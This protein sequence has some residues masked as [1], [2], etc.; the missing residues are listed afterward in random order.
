MRSYIQVAG[1]ASSRPERECSM[2]YDELALE[3]VDMA[4]GDDP[5]VPVAIAD[6]D[7]RPEASGIDSLDSRLMRVIRA[8]DR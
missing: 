7:P 8:L 2:I 1:S 3:P 5:V 4:L 6:V